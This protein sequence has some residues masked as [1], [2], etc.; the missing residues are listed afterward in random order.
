M[1]IGH[2]ILDNKKSAHIKA[3]K[4]YSSWFSQYGL[5]ISNKAVPIHWV[6]T[7]SL[8]TRHSSPSPSLS[9]INSVSNF[10]SFKETVALMR[11]PLKLFGD[12]WDNLES[13]ICIRGVCH[14]SASLTIWIKNIAGVSSFVWQKKSCLQWYH[15]KYDFDNEDI[16]FSISSDIFFTTVTRNEY[17]SCQSIPGEAICHYYLLTFVSRQKSK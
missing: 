3:K 15:V 10:Y 8:E 11:T 16:D 12:T 6:S 1:L 4:W 17:S 13:F 5:T 14:K 7:A 9:L 2:C